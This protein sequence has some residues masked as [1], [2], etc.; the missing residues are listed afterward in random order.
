MVA[1]RLLGPD[2][3]SLGISTYL[4]TCPAVW[5]LGAQA[6]LSVLPS[7]PASVGLAANTTDMINKL[8]YNLTSWTL[9]YIDSHEGIMVSDGRGA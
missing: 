8:N 7:I 2:S 1:Y 5:T 4:K 6:D 9:G 3:A